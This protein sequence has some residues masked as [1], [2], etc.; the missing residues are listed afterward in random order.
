[1]TILLTV[2]ELKD[3]LKSM[4][5]PTYGLKIELV[6]RLLD[7]G[8]SLEELNKPTSAHNETDHFKLLPPPSRSTSPHTVTSIPR[9]VNLLRRERDLAERETELLRR[10]VALLKT[11]PTTE[12]GTPTLA[13]A[14]KW[15][16][17][18]NLVG[19]YD[20][21]NLDFDLVRRTR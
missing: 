11:T 2:T 16:E 6:K 18:K 14:R 1:M 13:T 4:N 7:A 5:L 9:E 17:L 21:S 10:E 19:E 20:G 3:M 12:P 15:Q 8:V